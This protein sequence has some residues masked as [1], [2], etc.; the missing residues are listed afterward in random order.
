MTCVSQGG[1]LVLRGTIDETAKLVDLL[2]YACDGRLA[3]DLGAIS[4][5]NSPGVRAWISMQQVAAKQRVAL[6]LR[7]VSEPIVHQLNIV[8]AA[9]GVS[10]V[11]SFFAP[12]ECEECDREQVMLLDVR[13]HGA[14]LAHMRPPAMK[15]P[16]CKRSMSFAHPPELYFTFLAAPS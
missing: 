5:I 7:R 16:E 4:F 2:S 11:S 13:Q 15:C 10:L 1:Q 14:D 3:L 12:Y 6:E 9:R 8:P